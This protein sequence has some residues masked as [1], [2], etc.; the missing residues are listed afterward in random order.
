LTKDPSPRDS[1]VLLFT[2]F[3]KKNLRLTYLIGGN[4]VSS[5]TPSFYAKIAAMTIRDRYSHGSN[6]FT[7]TRL[8]LMTAI[9]TCF[10]HVRD[11][12][13]CITQLLTLCFHYDQNFTGKANFS[14]TTML[15]NMSSTFESYCHVRIGLLVFY[16]TLQQIV[17]DAP[18]HSYY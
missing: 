2:A 5:K 17:T 7:G 18:T 14:M 3:L 13:D 1:H 11:K 8:T 6:G 16:H 9:S 12:L 4:E 10:L 15:T